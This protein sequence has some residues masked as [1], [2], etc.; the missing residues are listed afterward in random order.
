MPFGNY[1]LIAK[2]LILPQTVWCLSV[3]RKLYPSHMMW[4]NLWTQTQNISA[5]VNTFSFHFLN[6]ADQAKFHFTE[7]ATFFAGWVEERNSEGFRHDSYCFSQFRLQPLQ[8]S[9]K[10]S[11]DLK[12]ARQQILFTSGHE[13]AV[14]IPLFGPCLSV[15]HPLT[16]PHSDPFCQKRYSWKESQ[17]WK[18]K[19]LQTIWWTTKI[20]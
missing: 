13:F 15:S 3:T 20:K 4:H 6:I 11:L 12:H 10:T 16:D 8:I 1:H 9:L 19:C 5:D 17:E 14:Q 2:Q 7:K 18:Q